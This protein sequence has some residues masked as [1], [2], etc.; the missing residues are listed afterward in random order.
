M[1]SAFQIKEQ[2]ITDTPLLLFHCQFHG[3]V[4]EAWSTHYVSCAGQN[5]SSRVLEHHVFELQTS[6]DQGVDFI[7]TISLTLA[8]ADAHFSQLE[9]N[10]GFKG[11]TVT[12][13]FLFF[14]LKQG[15]ATT[16][17]IVLFKGLFNP[18]HDITEA[19]FRISAVNKMNM[20]RVLLPQ[21]RVQRRC[22]WEF[23]ATLEQRQEA[24]SG[25][26]KGEYSRFYRCGY[27]PDIPGGTGRLN[28]DAPY[29]SCGFTRLECEAR[30]MFSND[31]ADNPTRRFGGIEFVPS[32]TLVRSYGE[33]SRHLSP[34]ATN[35]A[36]YNDFVPLVYG[37]VWYSPTVVF[38]K[39]DG[40][41][42]RM[43]VLLGLGEIN[44]VIKVLVND[45]DIPLG[46]AGINMTGTGWFNVVSTGARSGG[47]NPDFSDATGQPL[48]D[49]YGSMATL[50][51]VLPNRINDGRALPGI[52]VLLEGLKLPVYSADG[53]LLARHFTN[54]PAWVLLDVLRRSGWDLD[55][56]DMA[57]FAASA[58]YAGEQIVTQD[59]HG[60]SITVPRFECNLAL[61]RRR[62]AA[63]LIR[64]I[65]NGSRMYLTYG[66]NGL[67]QVAVENTT[68][69]QQPVPLE[70]SNSTNLLNG[71]WPSYE[72]GDGSSGV[73][74][75]MRRPGGESSVRVWSRSITDTPNR[76]TV[77][78]QDSL[79][80][81]QQDSFSLVDIEDVESGG[82]EITAPIMALGI[83]NYDQAARI[84]KFTLD[85]SIHGNTYVEFET[86]IK[87]L[88]IR[89]GDIIALTYLREGF[90]RQP[91]RVSRVAPGLNYRT[92]TLAA[93]IHDDAW[94]SDTN[95]QLTG[96]SGARRQTFF[97]V[98][99]P[100]PLLGTVVDTN[101]DIQFGIGEAVSQ[102]SDGT[103]IVEATV[104]FST[105]SANLSSAP[106]VPLVSLS[107]T[108]GSTGGTLAGGQ[109]V[110]YAASTINSAG[111]EGSLS[112]IIRA[113]IPAGPDTNTVTL[114][115]LSF[116][117]N[118]TSF[119]IYRG[120]SPVQLFRIA[121]NQA[122]SSSFTDTGLANQIIPPPD[123]NYDH[124]NFY[125]R[126]ELQPEYLSTLHS[127]TSAGNS[128]L[129]MTANAYRGM[130]AR[131]TR[132]KGAGQERSV[133]SNTLTSLEIAVAWDT[134]PDASSYFV[135][136]ES[137][138]HAG[139]KAKMSP[140]QLEIPNRTGATIHISGRSA[141]INDQESPLDLCTVTRWVIGGAGALDGDIPPMPSF[142]LALA[143][144]GG[145]IEL[146][147]VSFPDLANTHTI[148]AGTLSL[149]YWSELAGA[150]PR[151]VTS[152]ISA[153]DT[154]VDLTSAGSPDIGTFVQLEGEV[155]K[156]EAVLNSGTRYQL[157][158]GVHGSFAAAHA[159]G[160]LIYDLQNR[161]QI[162]PFV[163]DFFGSP[164]S[165]SWS[166]PIPLPDCRVA[167]A[168]LQ[169]VN[170]KGNSPTASI[171]LTQT[172]DFGL[173]TLSG[174]QF[175]FQVEGFL[176]IE[177]G[178]TPDVIVERAHSV[179]DIYALV[180]QAPSGGS[181]EL[182][183]K[184]NDVLYCSL[185]ITDG[186]TLSSSVSGFSL[187]PIIMGARLTL[188][189]V[190][191]GA[192][193]PG[194]DLTV[195]I[196]L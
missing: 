65:R 37:T 122:I 188:D 134:E 93:Q 183:I 176:A 138:W 170:I 62:T 59:L 114:T 131:I 126:L 17:P 147:G 159:A 58:A 98:G 120:S 96:S 104:S 151:A 42:T 119:H 112:F 171:C 160:V 26:T 113:T 29:T 166:F 177:M 47:F 78:F 76:F 140:V 135:V 115:G 95:G 189:V 94:Y 196:R 154:F 185:T 117:S 5:Y 153:E 57:T 195:I 72:F 121:S 33:Q 86:S 25:G 53:N 145:T 146:S 84:L 34:I 28:S 130:V 173:R 38:A 127:S 60:N 123:S 23:P 4:E 8:N 187:P 66:V 144:S 152:A 150:P 87:A 64:G 99:L 125:W 107:P 118:A 136:A 20:Q 51:I 70:W 54:N 19:V 36:H 139:A 9:R 148:S 97:G 88:G 63:D 43:E 85:K 109:S 48:G 83:S 102:T 92:A 157:T 175:S 172:D 71:G 156:V 137:G 101:G 49:P 129:Q 69:L 24:V 111:L 13:R 178:V 46:R 162:V 81:F 75:I 22:P 143:S 190:M 10:L 3:G 56:I 105:P 7:P 141:N 149:Y 31:N 165:G 27:S 167:S 45:I 100:R 155:A 193:N 89:P 132:G 73:S 32:A 21:V 68:A 163:R 35:E 116:P 61:T 50:S 184:Q 182:Q 15:F 80:E 158:R 128:N 82:Q 142:G 191:V 55:E 179:K 110:Y 74:G 18:P 169:V 77:E 194:A 11:S 180:R 16:T 30:G 133:L 79:N 2:A 124:A 161:T 181:V 52:K 90:N 6:S 103:Q 40:N 108:L 192:T 106:A 44:D 67:L 14:D 174:G 39:N 164:F 12:V 168:E 1:P 41:L 91:F 186:D